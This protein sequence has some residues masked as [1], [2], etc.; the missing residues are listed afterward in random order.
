MTSNRLFIL[1]VFTTFFLLYFLKEFINLNE[2]ID[3]ISYSVKFNEKKLKE[4]I[5]DLSTIIFD[6]ERELSCCKDSLITKQS[7]DK[8]EECYD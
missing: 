3:Q 6:T 5:N 2:K 7:K 4:K 8:M 1:Q